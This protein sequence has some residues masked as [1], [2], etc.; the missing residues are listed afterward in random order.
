MFMNIFTLT[1]LLGVIVSKIN[2]QSPSTFAVST[3]AG[4]S[5]CAAFNIIDIKKLNVTK[6]DYWTTA[7][8]CSSCAKHPSCGYCVSTLTCLEGDVYGPIDGSPCPD[9]LFQEATVAEM[10]LHNKAS[11]DDNKIKV[12]SSDQPDPKMCPVRPKCNEFSGCDRCALAPECA[13][14]ASR[15]ACIIVSEVFEAPVCRGTVFD[16]PCPATFVGVNRV[17]GN[18]VIQQDPV[19]GGGELNVA[20][21]ATDGKPFELSVTSTG[22][23]IQS[24]RSIVL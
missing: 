4:A 13:W 23:N 1:I 11:N 7:S 9:F 8:G 24:A 14:C 17:I 21:R 6:E 2:S 20:G 3:S 19:F 18:L 12:A 10:A 16:S 15:D 5:A 22:T